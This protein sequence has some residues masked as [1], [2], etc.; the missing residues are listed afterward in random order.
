MPDVLALGDGVIEVEDGQ[1]VSVL[2]QIGKSDVGGA[3]TDHEVYRDETLE[4]DGP[5]RVSEAVLEG[6]D[7][8]CYAALARVCR[9]EDV[10]DVLC[11]GRRILLGRGL[12]TIQ[13]THWK[14]E[15]IGSRLD[16]P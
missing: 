9:N 11:L 16:G 7:D 3:L 13:A 2:G 1:G 14:G 12:V 5:C 15:W 4:D 6:P 8:V 10:L